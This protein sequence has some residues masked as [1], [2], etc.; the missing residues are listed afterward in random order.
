MSHIVEIHSAV[1]A[2]P[3]SRPV[4]WANVTVTQREFVLCWVVD[5][6][7]RT[8]SAYGMGSRFP[9]G[10]NL[11]HHAI[12]DNLKPVVLNK[13]PMMS[14]AIWEAMY[15]QTILI[16]RQG[17]VMRALSCIDIAIWDLKAKIVNQ[18]LYKLLGGFTD[19]VKAYASGGYYEAGKDAAGLAKE[20]EFYRSRGFDSFKIKI[21]L[22]SPRQE[23]ER[24]AA[25]REAAGDGKLAVDANNA[26][27]SM[28][29]AWPYVRLLEKYDLWWLEEPFSPDDR[30]A[31]RELAQRT[32]LPISSGELECGRDSFREYIEARSVH[33][34][35]TDASVV[36][37]ITEWKRVAA[38]AAGW[39]LPLAPHWI[40]EVHAHLLAS[41]PNG[42]PVEYFLPESEILNFIKLVE[43]PLEATNGRIRLGDEP[44][45]GIRYNR[46]AIESY[47]QVGTL[48]AS[49]I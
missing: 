31:Y 36:G 20:I 21:G 3:L 34:L 16:G 1:V 5:S 22:L 7:G 33:I 29:E 8:G 23:D 28:A 39:N 49:G 12:Q 15:R 10:A 46:A 4:G 32:S 41:I 44:G 30:P 35:Q 6:E 47:L 11:I 43:N 26:W 42:W 25:A 17:A 48:P 19:E 18:P 24:I 37:G 13:D 14:E 45:H 2:I 40:P 27:R 9:L 38:M